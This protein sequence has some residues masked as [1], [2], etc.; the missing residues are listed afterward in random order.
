MVKSLRL[1]WIGRLLDGTNANW[2]AIPDYFYNKCGGL[3]FFK[4]K[5]QLWC[6]F[7]WSEFPP[8]LLRTTRIFSRIEQWIGGE[9]RRKFILWNSKDI[10]IDQKSLFWETWFERGIYYLQDLLNED[11]KILSLDE[12]NGN[13][14]LKANYLRKYCNECV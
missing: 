2:K 12:F 10:T 8:V 3:T 1:S 7:I 6:K 14:R 9:P 11:G 4:I 5:V 13:F